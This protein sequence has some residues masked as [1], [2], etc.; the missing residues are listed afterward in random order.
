MN[1]PQVRFDGP[2]IGLEADCLGVKF[3]PQ[4]LEPVVIFSDLSFHCPAGVVTAVAGPSGSGK[5]TLLDCIVGA[6]PY[7]G[8]IH[9]VQG[10]ERVDGLQPRIA[11]S[12]QATQLV[13]YLTV[14]ENLD[15]AANMAKGAT[16]EF[17]VVD[18]SPLQALGLGDLAGRYPAT[19]SGGE[20]ARVGLVRALSANPDVL[21]VDEP[22]ASLDRRSARP[23]VDGLKMLVEKFGVT[24][25]V[26]THDPVVESIA[27][28]RIELNRD[29]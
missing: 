3:G 13:S 22:T 12:F 27:A 14:Q 6:V 21:L 18:E 17:G 16:R 15:F 9:F 2:P 24:V 7:E 23:V 8:S 29:F 10:R 28:H 26:A 19:L 20:L 25:I 5:T 11:R 4:G 1:E